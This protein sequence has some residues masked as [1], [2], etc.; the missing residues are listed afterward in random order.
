MTTRDAG[1]NGYKNI[2]AGKR[3]EVRSRVPPRK[4]T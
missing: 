1:R 2:W 4:V 3:P